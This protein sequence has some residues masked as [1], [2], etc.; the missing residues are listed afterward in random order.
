[1]AFSVLLL[2]G[3]SPPPSLW[4]VRARVCE[5]VSPR[6]RLQWQTKPTSRLISLVLWRL[7]CAFLWRAAFKV[8]RSMPRCDNVSPRLTR[9]MQRRSR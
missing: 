5:G 9:L 6:L 2:F 7:C 1:M 8:Q 4:R 3:V